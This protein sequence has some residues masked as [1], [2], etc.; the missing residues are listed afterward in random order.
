[1]WEEGKGFTDFF[2]MFIYSY[3][4]ISVIS[5]MS[6]PSDNPYTV[7][8]GAASLCAQLGVSLGRFSF[9]YHYLQCS[10][11]WLLDENKTDVLKEVGFFLYRQG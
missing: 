1:M 9:K 10:S 11:A 8:W 4:M 2:H 6:S 3:I 5:P 7:P